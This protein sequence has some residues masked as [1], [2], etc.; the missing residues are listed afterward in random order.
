MRERRYAF[1]YQEVTP[2]AQRAFVDANGEHVIVVNGEEERYP[3]LEAMDEVSR[4]YF[5]MLCGEPLPSRFM[6]LLNQRPWE[7]SPDESSREGPLGE[8]EDAALCD[9]PVGEDPIARLKASLSRY[10]PEC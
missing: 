9:E 1:E 3:S 4:I 7:D 8:S 6:E 2:E 10:T 5:Q